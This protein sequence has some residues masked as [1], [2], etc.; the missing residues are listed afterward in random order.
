MFHHRIVGYL[1]VLMI[2]ALLAPNAAFAQE[3]A[4]SLDQLRL[5]LEKGDKITVID[6]S[7][8]NFKGIVE[9]IAPDAL[10]LKVEGKI[11]SFNENN[12]R[13]ITR[14]KQDSALNGTLIGAAV[15]FGA[16]LPIALGF[17][18]YD[19]KGAAVAAAGIW[20][21]IGA[22]IGALVDVSV[23]ENQMVYF[24]PKGSISWSISP[25]FRKS[26]FRVQPP[27]ERS[28]LPF[29][30]NNG[31]DQTTGLALTIRF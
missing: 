27:G 9:K 2:L 28:F 26:A 24:H 15:G 5:L 16:T 31:M 7:G 1:G 8:R 19:E 30:P 10:D 22:G 25:I 23:Q 11:Q 6:S 18:G 14:R 3:P 12:L 13:R 29:Q 4:T 21:L 20:G 17:S